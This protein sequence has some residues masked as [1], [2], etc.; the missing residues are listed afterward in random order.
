MLTAQVESLALRL[1][2]LKPM[3]PRHYAE[4]ALDQDKVPL[5]PD[6]DQYLALDARGEVLFVTMLEQGALAG[7]FVGFVKPHLHYKST[8]HCFM[9]IY[10][11]APEFRGQR[12]FFTLFGFVETE[13][14]RRGVKKPYFGSKLHKD[15]GGLFERIGMKPADTYYSAWWGD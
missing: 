6:Y 8:L 1:D 13:C 4:L 5:D 2:E 15:T 14:K 7:Y 10:W 3:L 12:G 11:I 9:D